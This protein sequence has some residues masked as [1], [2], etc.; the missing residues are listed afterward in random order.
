[1]EMREVILDDAEDPGPD[2]FFFCL[3]DVTHDT[4]KVNKKIL[5]GYKGLDQWDAVVP[6]WADKECRKIPEKTRQKWRFNGFFGGTIKI[7]NQKHFRVVDKKL[8]KSTVENTIWLYCPS[9]RKG[10]YH[11]VKSMIKRDPKYRHYTI[12]R[13]RDNALASEIDK[14][15]AWKD[16]LFKTQ[17]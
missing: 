10:N 8:Q 3:I 5:R 7:V 17:H 11:M 9:K 13:E 6:I 1:M 12:E 14:L 4:Y 2:T 15:R 16:P